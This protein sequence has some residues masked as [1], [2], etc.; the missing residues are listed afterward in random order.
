M[1][2]LRASLGQRAHLGVTLNLTPIYAADEE[3]ET[4]QRVRAAD[5][6]H[7]QWFLQPLFEARYAPD[8][9]SSLGV[10]EPPIL[11]GDM[12]RIAAPLD[13]LGVNYYERQVFR[14]PTLPATARPG[15]HT[16]QVV[17]VPGASY[18]EMGWE[19]GKSIRK[20]W[21]MCSSRSTPRTIRAR[22]S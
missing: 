9:F 6:L 15:R 21:R 4:L 3:A 12:E 7:N 18:T 22:S 5:L 20:A 10:G 14:T 13:F 11:D 19:V 1:E 8:L 16:Q 2:R 17:P